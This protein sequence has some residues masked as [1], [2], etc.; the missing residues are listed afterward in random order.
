LH[1]FAHTYIYALL[2]NFSG[3]F[4]I[5]PATAHATLTAA[6]RRMSADGATQ[7]RRTPKKDRTL[8][9]K[10]WR[11]LMLTAYMLY[12][13]YISLFAHAIRRLIQFRIYIM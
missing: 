11:T 7:R 2:D 9:A 6:H 10:R 13:S 3:I 4:S 1:L 5:Y 8:S 12:G